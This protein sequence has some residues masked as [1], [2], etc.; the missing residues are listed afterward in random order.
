MEQTVNAKLEDAW[1]VVAN[2]ARLNE[3]A[4]PPYAE[5][6][7]KGHELTCETRRRWLYK[8]TYTWKLSSAEEKD[9]TRIEGPVERT[10]KPL[11]WFIW[12]IT[13]GK[14]QH[15]PDIGVN[16][17]R[18]KI[19][20]EAPTIILETPTQ[21]GFDLDA[22]LT[23]LNVYTTQFGSY[24]TLLWQVPVLG[25]TAQA[26][27]MTIALGMGISDDARIAASA[28][29]IIIAW[30]SWRLMH[31][32][33]GR[34]INQ[35]ELAREEFPLYF[36]LSSSSVAISRLT[37]LCRKILMRRTYGT[38]ITASIRSGEFAWYC[39]SLQTLL[40]SHLSFSA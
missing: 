35:A 5:P 26:F 6:T 34:A 33:R 14:E 28:L 17:T 32:Q 12:L 30:A 4:P 36:R 23:L 21:K 18:L 10:R 7:C 25:L 13:L 27:L 29:S 3:W 8:D 15:K 1:A 39:F 2:E 38:W 11:G 40:L 24:T 9:H 22:L 20:L 16:F 37:M 19:I 31:T